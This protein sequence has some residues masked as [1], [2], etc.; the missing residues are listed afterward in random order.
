MFLGNPE[1][2]PHGDPIPNTNGQIAKSQH[3]ILLSKAKSG[4]SYIVSRLSSSDK[5]FFDFC[6]SYHI[7]V[8]FHIYIEKQLETQKMTEIKIREDKILL[9]HEFTNTIY[10]KPL[11]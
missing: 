11:E 9:N 5:D 7:K 4:K 3:E 6:A 10:V 8:G 2:D 1:V